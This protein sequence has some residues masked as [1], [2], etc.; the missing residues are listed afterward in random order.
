MLNNPKRSLDSN[1]SAVS[2]ED[3]AV[4]KHGKRLKQTGGRLKVVSETMV[5][6]AKGRED[7][8]ALVTV[9]SVDSVPTGSRDLLVLV[10]C[11]GSMHPN[12]K[13][14]ESAIHHLSSHSGDDNAEHVNIAIGT[15]SSTSFIPGIASDEKEEEKEKEEKE[16]QQEEQQE[17]EESKKIN[18]E[19]PFGYAPWK[20]LKETTLPSLMNFTNRYVQIDGSTNMKHM[21]ENALSTLKKRRECD[22]QNRPD[23]LQH[24]VILTDGV[25]DP[26]QTQNVLTKVIEDGIGDDAVV[27]SMLLLGTHVNLGLSEAISV[28]TTH[29]IVSYADK[30]D[31]LKKSFDEI[32]NQVLKS[33]RAFNV[34]I[35]DSGGRI[36]V[37]HCGVLTENNNAA[38]VTFNFGPKHYSDHQLGCKMVLN[39]DV[40][41]TA[42]IFPYYAT[43]DEDSN[44]NSELAKVPAE[45]KAYLDAMEIEE[46]IKREVM[47][48]LRNEGFMEA[49]NF[50]NALTLQY[51]STLTAPAL[52]RLSGFSSEL[53]LRS[54]RSN[55]ST[56]TPIGRILS[57]TASYSQAVY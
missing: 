10:D 47:E 27:V 39:D 42:C 55:A 29:G 23:H 12:I 28:G 11:S 38:L 24:L 9:D 1:V 31:E 48:K 7:V 18:D 3:P 46:N 50:A 41:T 6:S 2:A 16:Q 32:L 40:S 34:K 45:L 51:Q 4:T 25:P 57:A 17:E 43:S 8:R 5:V 49:S 21:L 26:G 53:M 22:F 13:Q 30:P 33:S 37:Q 54:Q 36:R 19:L 15:Y 56:M 14:L 52:R 20:T 35:Y 44:W